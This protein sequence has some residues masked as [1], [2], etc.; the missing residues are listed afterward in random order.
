DGA[1]FYRE[2]APVDRTH[3]FLATVRAHLEDGPRPALTW[4]PSSQGTADATIAGLLHRFR[5]ASAVR[6]KPGLGETTRVLLR[7]P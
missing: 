7:Q 6:L 2:L 1:V 4:R 5:V 3:E